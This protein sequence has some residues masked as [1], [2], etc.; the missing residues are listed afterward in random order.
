[1]GIQKGET[2]TERAQPL[3]LFVSGIANVAQSFAGYYARK[4]PLH[5][6]SSG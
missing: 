1:M 5:W 6:D 2:G 4:F 3:T